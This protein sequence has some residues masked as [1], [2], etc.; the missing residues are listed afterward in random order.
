MTGIVNNIAESLSNGAQEQ[1]RQSAEKYLI[2]YAKLTP[3]VYTSARENGIVLTARYLVDPRKRRTTEQEIWE[4][5]L[6]KFRSEK[7]III[8]YPATRVYLEK[9]GQP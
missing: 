9:P 3:I 7:D 6:R 1:I 4:E 2:Y 8:A 5:V